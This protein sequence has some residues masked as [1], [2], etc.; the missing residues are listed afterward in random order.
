[1]VSFDFAVAQEQIFALVLRCPRAAVSLLW[2]TQAMG[3]QNMFFS[4][5]LLSAP[6]IMKYDND[7]IIS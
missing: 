5:F 3:K 2:H 4:S 6:K 7:I 1:M